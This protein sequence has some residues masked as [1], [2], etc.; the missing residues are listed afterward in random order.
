MQAKEL[1]NFVKDFAIDAYLANRK[2]LIH[3]Y[4][5]PSLCLFT[6]RRDAGLGNINYSNLGRYI[7]LGCF[8]NDDFEHILETCQHAVD[9]L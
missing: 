7:Y 3:M 9:T 8:K 5:R 2:G 4:Y 1:N 6:Y